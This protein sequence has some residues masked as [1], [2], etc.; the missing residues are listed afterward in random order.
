M[1]RGDVWL[2]GLDPTSGP[3]QQRARPVLVVS[4]AALN[5][6]TGT[7]IVL[8]ISTCGSF[9]RRRGFAVSLDKADIRTKGAIRCDQPRA[10][11]LEARNGRHIDTVPQNIA[12]EVTARLVTLLE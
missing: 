3:E 2:V 4:H 10:L 8:P 12:D 5:E 11:H 6:V 9:Q 7:P 1:K